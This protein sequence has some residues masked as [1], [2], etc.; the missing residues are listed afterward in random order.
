MG[1]RI[2]GKKYVGKDNKVLFKRGEK[3]KR[4]RKL[5]TREILLQLLT[6]LDEKTLHGATLRA[7]YTLAFAAFLRCG[8]FTYTA[9]EAAALGFE[10]WYLTRK[11]I[12]IQID[13]MTVSLPASKTDPFRK[14]IVLTVAA[15][16]YDACAV[17]AMKNLFTRFPRPPNA[18]LFHQQHRAFTRDYVMSNLKPVMRFLG[19]EGNYSGHSFRRGAATSAKEAGLCDADIQI[20]GRWKSDAYRLYIDTPLTHIFETSKRFQKPHHHHH[21]HH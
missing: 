3:D 6:S 18:P 10:E 1:S 21:H 7:A 15:V 4:E 13:R 11:S 16:N 2:G 5:I 14:G 20:L 12:D 8:E 19:H 9:G 17:T